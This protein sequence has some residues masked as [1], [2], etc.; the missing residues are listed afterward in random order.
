MNN[1]DP[2]VKRT[3]TSRQRTLR[4][5]MQITVVA[6]FVIVASLSPFRAAG[7]IPAQVDTPP[8][9]PPSTAPALS[10]SAYLTQALQFIETQALSRAKVDWAS[11]RSA[12]EQ[13]GA[14]AGSI[15]ETYPIISDVLKQLGDPHS[16]FR[17]PAKATE[18]T[19]GQANGYGFLASWPERIVVSI[20]DGGPAVAAG[21]KLRDE[22][23]LI[24]GRKPTGARQVVAIP[25]KTKIKDALRLTVLRRSA[26]S[27]GSANSGSAAKPKRIAITIRKGA[28]S[29]VTAPKPDPAAAK[30][31]G[32]RLGYIELPGLLGTEQDQLAYAQSA[33]DAIRLIDQTPRCGWIVDVRRN[34]GGWVYP[35][36]AA[37]APLLGTSDANASTVLMGKVDAAGI[38]ETWSYQGGAVK[39]KRPGATPEEYAVFSVVNPFVVTHPVSIAVLSSGLTASAGEA[40]VLSYRGKA[41]SKS[42]GQTTLGLTT[43]DVVGALPDGALLLVSNAAMTDQTFRA[44]EGPIQPDAEVAP[45]WNHVGDDQ[46]PIL[47]AATQWLNA[48]SSCRQ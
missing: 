2:I 25:S 42:F 40:V 30:T 31:I 28:V 11:I 12:A 21:L 6:A 14:K 24:E 7:A 3:R 36:L 18:V 1:D 29:L 4:K 10:P 43:F 48:Q 13:R 38:T 20:T 45:D 9:S 34:R 41:N 26:P 17:P 15:P 8:S 33:H 44:Q 16:S 32:D 47:N 19:Q 39:V 35:I 37:T 23:V 22:I 5:P 27:S 46:D